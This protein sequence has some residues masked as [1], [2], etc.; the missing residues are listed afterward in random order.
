MRGPLIAIACTAVGCNLLFGFDDLHPVDAA[1][2]APQVFSSPGPHGSGYWFVAPATVTLAAD[3]P[4]PTH[5]MT[6][7]YYTTDGSTPTLDSPHGMSPLK[8]IS[9]TGPQT[10]TYFGVSPTGSGSAIA[11]HYVYDTTKTGSAG[12]YI[13]NITLDGTSPVVFVHAG[14]VLAGASATLKV[15]TGMGCSGCTVQIVFGVDDTD[16]GCVYSG[17]PGLYAPGVSGVM[18]SFTV[19][20]PMD[21][22]VHRVRVA[23]IEETDCGSAMMMNTLKNRP[24]VSQIGVLIVQ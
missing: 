14:Q 20:A 3:D 6:V 17:S 4:D 12:Y 8:G 2:P 15:W 16:Q 10:L 1:G 11:E 22:G 9:I 24:D 18:R 7:I 19:T 23:D 13:S 21:P 5:P